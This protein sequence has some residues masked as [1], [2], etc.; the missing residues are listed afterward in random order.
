MVCPGGKIRS[1]GKFTKIDRPLASATANAYGGKRYIIPVGFRL[2]RMIKQV[3][4]RVQPDFGSASS[5]NARQHY[6][7]RMRHSIAYINRKF[8]IMLLETR[9]STKSG[10]RNAAPA[11]AKSVI[12]LTCPSC[13]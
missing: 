8:Q 11:N 1:A 7:R 2:R 10:L 6:L 3:S 12:C 13:V 4:P 9:G 5:L